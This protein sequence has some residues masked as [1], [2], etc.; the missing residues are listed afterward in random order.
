MSLFRLTTENQTEVRIQNNKTTE[1]VNN[2]I[3]EKIYWSEYQRGRESFYKQMDI[4]LPY[5]QKR[6]FDYTKMA[7]ISPE[8]QAKYEEIKNKA[9]VDGYHAACDSFHCPANR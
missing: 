1:A 4:I 6:S 8:E 5:D 9:Y 7:K 2:D 3:E